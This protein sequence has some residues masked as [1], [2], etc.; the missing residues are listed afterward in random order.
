MKAVFIKSALLL[1]VLSTVPG[2]NAGDKKENPAEKKNG[3]VVDSGAFGIF[4]D[5]KRVG[6]ETFSIEQMADYA[7]V[8]AE[9][10][11]DDGKTKSIQNAEMQI[12]P[13]GELRSYAW[14]S[15]S[16][17]KEENTV[18][19]N[20]QFMIEH[21]LPADQKK[22]DMPHVLPLS[23]IILD[24]NFFSQREILVWRYLAS[25]CKT[26]QVFLDT[27]ANSGLIRNGNTVTAKTRVVHSYTAGDRVQISGSVDSSFSGIFQVASVPDNTHFT[28]AQGGPNATSGQGSVS[29]IGEGLTCSPGNFGFLIPRQHIAGNATIELVGQDRIL[30][31]GATR[32]LNK[33]SV[34]TGGPKGI[35]MLNG[36]K[37]LDNIEWLLWVDDQ[38]KVLKMAVPS[39]NIEAIRD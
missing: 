8:S 18:E 30:L 19:P 14:H 26:P 12:R 34:K 3:K 2:L 5:G 15:I 7:V 9:I 4:V 31:K 16:P 6:T 39:S 36:Q 21:I 28:Y 37:D 1:A 25:G 35:T 13:N 38:Y 32:E 27:P 17:Q 33:L 11:V 20:D 29:K 24:D 22:I 10:K 23:T